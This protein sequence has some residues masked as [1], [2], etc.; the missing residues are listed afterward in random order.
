MHW[1]GLYGMPR[2]IP[3]YPT[4]KKKN[5]VFF[6]AAW[7]LVCSYG[8]YVSVASL[9][10]FFFVVGEAFIVAKPAPRNPWPVENKTKPTAVYSLEWLYTSPMDFH[11]HP[12]LPVIREPKN[13]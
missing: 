12:E 7:N 3:D 1:L 2:R 11:T 6:N 8:A 4:A 10:V 9:I 5:V 13:K